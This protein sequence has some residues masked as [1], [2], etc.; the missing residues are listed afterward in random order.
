MSTR[1]ANTDTARR[2]DHADDPRPRLRGIPSQETCGHDTYVP[3][4]CM[5]FWSWAKAMA[6][7]TLMTAKFYCAE[8]RMYSRP[9]PR[10]KYPRT[11]GTIY[12]KPLLHILYSSPLILLY[13]LDAAATTTTL[14]SSTLLFLSNIY[15]HHLRFPF[16]I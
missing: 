16:S 6:T 11:H 10:T 13:T 3:Q 12:H 9:V 15:I 8:V 2:P 1:T 4:S 5:R 7:A 14:S